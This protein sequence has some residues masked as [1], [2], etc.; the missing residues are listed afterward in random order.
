M[1]GKVG[2]PTYVTAPF[3][4]VSTVICQFPC[5]ICTQWWTYRV[6]MVLFRVETKQMFEAAEQ[7]KSFAGVKLRHA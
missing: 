7:V 5:I 1:N 4:L 2:I 6:R 3:V